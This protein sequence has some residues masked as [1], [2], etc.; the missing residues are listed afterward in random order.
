M[1]GR[2][3]RWSKA[4]AS[5]VALALLLVGAVLAQDPDP[6]TAPDPKAAPGKDA[7]KEKAKT[8]ARKGR[9]VRTPSRTPTKGVPKAVDALANPANV[10]GVLVP[11]GQPLPA[12]G[13]FHYRFKI[14]VGETEP[15]SVAYYPSKTPSTNTPVVMLIHE[16]ERS[17]KDFEEPIA[18]L[19]KLSLA[20]ELQKQGYT[21]LALDLRGH[22]GSTP[23]RTLPKADWPAVVQDL[24][25]AYLCLVD[26]HNWGELNLGKL[27]VVAMGEGAN[28]AAYWAATGRGGVSSEGRTTDVISMVLVS[29]MIDAQSQGIPF[30]PTVTAIAQRIKLDLLVGEK[31]TASAPL[32]D[33][34]P[35]SVKPIVARVRGNLI[36]TFP[37][38]LHG[39][40]LLQ[41]EPNLT[42]SIIRFLDATSKVNAQVWDGR[43]LLTPVTYSE[44]KV[45]KNPVRIDPATKK[46][47]N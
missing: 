7:D 44:I 22:G 34:S 11:P 46:A 9:L 23:R 47:A 2:R 4:L 18:E 26:R 32:I 6:K 15:L 31:D 42:G 24:Q 25:T 28:V 3:D 19:K 27:G 45:I 43:Y 29:P 1:R 39:Y 17:A 21:V 5:T 35:A 8:T 12:P 10:D 33:D 13:T 16:R 36:E 38:A 40:K 20:E 37:S 41:F 30:K 14:A